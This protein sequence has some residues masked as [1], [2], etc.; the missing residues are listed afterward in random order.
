M[1]FTQTRLNGAYI[2]DI[3]PINDDRGFFARSWCEKEFSE[4]DLP[5]RIAQCNIS[6]NKEK[7][8]LRGLHFQGHPFEEDKIIRCINGSLFDVIVDI[9]PNSKTYLEWFGI[10]LSSENKRSMF[11]PKGFA[12][13]FQT[14]DDETEVLYQISEFYKPSHSMGIKFDDPKIGVVWPLSS[15]IISEKDRSYAYIT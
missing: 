7:G 10:E 3:E 5:Y 15:P 13:G 14:L 1:Q 4:K 6:Y 9:R 2:I 12:H 8:T 11:I